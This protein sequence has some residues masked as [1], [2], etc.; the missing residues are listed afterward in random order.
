MIPHTSLIQIAVQWPHALTV[1]SLFSGIYVGINVVA[2]HI[3][4]QKCN[5]PTH[6]FFENT[7]NSQWHVIHILRAL[8][9]SKTKCLKIFP[10]HWLN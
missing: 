9:E 4:K 7:V 8:F 2:T 10:T 6:I 5:L 3:L 1:P